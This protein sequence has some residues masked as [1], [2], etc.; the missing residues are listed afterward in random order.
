MTDPATYATYPTFLGLRNAARDAAITIAGVPLDLGTTNRS[1]TRF[2]PQAIR[3]ASRMLVDGAHPE[4]GIDPRELDLADIGDIEPVIGDLAASH[5]AIESAARG[6]AHLITLGGDHSLTLP[7]LRALSARHKP[8]A[9]VHFDAHIDT[10]AD[11]F[12]QPLAHGS[13]FYHAIGEGLVD[14]LRHVV[15]GARSPVD[16]ETMAWTREK[17]IT[18]LSA[19][20][21]H[22]SDVD[23]IAARVREVVGTGPVYLSF[24]IDCLDP[25]AA[26]GTGTPEIG[27]LFGWQARAILKRLGGL[28]W[29]GM[30]VVEV[31][32]AYDISEITALAAATMVFEYL[33]LLGGES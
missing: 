6:L 17:G 11:N 21:V 19:E 13:P 4:S 20:D 15:I 27:G 23:S 10:W 24:D 2:G 3:I 22:L 30:D 33:C 26:P 5:A 29:V 9:L 25:S 14:P 16:R 31:A 28:D 12:G 18:I 1:G 7:I 8:V 32:P